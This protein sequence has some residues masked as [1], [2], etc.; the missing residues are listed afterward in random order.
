MNG[1]FSE[2]RERS[3]GPETP[4]VVRKL[5]PPSWCS[6]KESQRRSHERAARSP[7]VLVPKSPL[8]YV[9]R[10]SMHRA[11]AWRNASGC[12]AI[13]RGLP[14][15]PPG[16]SRI[17]PGVQPQQW[18]GSPQRCTA[19]TARPPAAKNP[20]TTTSTITSFLMLR[21]CAHANPGGIG[22]APE[23]PPIPPTAGSGSPLATIRPKPGW[24]GAGDRDF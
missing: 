17:L 20:T 15:A 6:T 22:D 16:P 4:Y 7:S 19:P 24:L 1:S 9:R 5:A 8:R 13:G 23:K 10:S 12:C 14:L 18:P 3:S 21:W 2:I 11:T